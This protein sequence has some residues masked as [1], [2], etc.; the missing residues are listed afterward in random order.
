MRRSDRATVPT[1]TTGPGQDLGD[2][3]RFQLH[4]VVE[5]GATG[6][7]VAHVAEIPGCVSQGKTPEEAL[8]ALGEALDVYLT[9]LIER[10]RP[11][12]MQ[13]ALRSAGVTDPDRGKL[14]VE[15]VSA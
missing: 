4:A 7:Y 15:L 3:P 5:P 2:A 6:V 13:E 9:A 10:A 11:R 14:E 1:V 12:W 8:D